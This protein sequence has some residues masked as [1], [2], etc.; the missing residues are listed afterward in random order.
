[1]KKKLAL[2]LVATMAISLVGCGAKEDN[3]NDT[4]APVENSSESTLESDDDG[5]GETTTSQVADNE[6]TGND[7]STEET[8]T[9]KQ[10][11]TTTKK[12]EETT[13]KKPE[14]TT[15]KKPAETTTKKPDEKPVETEAPIVKKVGTVDEATYN[16]AVS[17]FTNIVKQ[18]RT[19]GIV[20][21]T[22]VCV[23]MEGKDIKVDIR[24]TDNDSDLI[25]SWDATN[26]TYELTLDYDFMWLEGF[27]EKINGKDPAKYNESLFR[28][29]L[30]MFT[31]DVDIVFNRIDSD[32]YSA[33]GLY[34][35]KWTQ[36]ADISIRSGK[37][38]VD[39][40]FSYFITKEDVDSRDKTYTLT[41]TTAD[42]KTV[43]CVIE[44]DSSKV[45]YEQRQDYLTGEMKDYMH[46]PTDGEEGSYGHLYI[47]SGC[48]SFDEYKQMMIQKYK[49]LGDPNPHFADTYLVTHQVNGYT[50]YLTEFFY[51]Y[52]DA[53]GDPD[54]VYVQIG[55]NLYV[56]IF[57]FQS[58]S[59]FED[60][61]ID[62]F[63]IKE[64]KVK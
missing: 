10:E 32:C 54:V 45:T 35:D 36:I 53:K 1:M 25:L 40:C 18:M 43:E 41:G 13:T 49:D 61:V 19:D 64:V 29:L 33:F 60:S 16:K 37:F 7:Q 28:A 12:P 63:F 30:C 56:E 50:Y 24:Y 52:A 39:K 4:K 14:E 59:R 3:G 9:G 44:Y 20:K 27:S 17:A 8:T 55:D 51:E 22:D 34:K 15:T 46:H 42:G 38:E 11:E 5:A 6:T 23:T 26:K 48:N 21:K 47:R 2:L 31:D 62:S 58:Y 57:N